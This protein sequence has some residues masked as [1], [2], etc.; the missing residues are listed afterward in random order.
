[1]N[2]LSL[3]WAEVTIDLMSCE[4]RR[5]LRAVKSC[6]LSSLEVFSSSPRNESATALGRSI[7]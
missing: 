2:H 3:N 4:R 7:I 1:M 6:L 5:S